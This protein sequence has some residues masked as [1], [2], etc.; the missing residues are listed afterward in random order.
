MSSLESIQ[1]E[2]KYWIKILFHL[3]TFICA[4]SLLVKT[5]HRCTEW[6]NELS[7]FTSG[8][9]VNPTNVKLLNNVGRLYENQGNLSMALSFY[10]KAVSIQ[11]DDVRGYLN[12]GKALTK[13]G[14]LE[15][16]ER[17]YRKALDLIPRPNEI[18]SKLNSNHYLPVSH[19]H[20]YNENDDK[21]SE[22][23]QREQQ[24][25]PPSSIKSSSYGD[26]RGTEQSIVA[27]TGRLTLPGYERL[28]NQGTNTDTMMN[29]NEGNHEVKVS[30]SLASPSGLPLADKSGLT[31]ITLNHLQGLLHYASLISKDERRLDEANRMFSTIA[32]MRPDYSVTYSTWIQSMIHGNDQNNDDGGTRKGSPQN[33]QAQN[34]Q[35]LLSQVTSNNKQTDP[36]I[37]Y[38]MAIL[39]NN[40]GNIENALNLFDQ[41]LSI[42]PYHEET[43]LTSARIIKD[44]ELIGDYLTIAMERLETL[45]SMGKADE[46]VYFDLGMLAIRS[47][48]MLT[49]R[50]YFA[51]AIDLKPNFTEALFNMA[52]LL[53]KDEKPKDALPFLKFLLKTE[54]TH[55]KALLLM[56]AINSSNNDADEQND[57]PKINFVD[58]LCD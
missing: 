53:Y 42:D 39:F 31:A 19:H 22:D 20:P 51:K 6:Q 14:R 57:L 47:G 12:L 11:P 40:N 50:R 21:L 38:N 2:V 33:D 32:S 43:L 56:V 16:A 10:E 34:G 23:K 45:V 55:G 8:L 18:S 27:S 30:P 4:S 49:A 13:I 29:H 46:T 44:N 48:H 37:L 52:L 15:E 26:D 7:L 35:I 58:A 54:E 25:L 36:D 28:V 3:V 9:N 41:A 5:V 24:E 17:S 1:G